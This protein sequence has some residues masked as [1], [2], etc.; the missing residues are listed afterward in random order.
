MTESAVL[1]E[2]DFFIGGERR[3][4]RDGDRFETVDP[5]TGEPWAAS[6]RPTP[7]TSTR[8]CA[9]RARRSTA[10]RGARS[11]RAR[12]GRLLMRLAD[13]I[14]EHVRAHRLARDAR[15]RQALQGDARPAAAGAGVAPLLRRARRQGR[16]PTIPLDRPSVLNYTAARAARRRRDHHP[17]E[18][19]GVAHDDGRS[20]RRWPPATPSSS[21]RRR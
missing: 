5:T 21:S 16:G 14:S 12:R 8:A 15:Q 4:A 13:A 17:V 1:E 19:A 2:L 20:R 11:P 3:P 18:L 7:T 10:P 6:R 9:A